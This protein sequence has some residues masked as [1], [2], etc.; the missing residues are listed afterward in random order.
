MLDPKLIQQ[1]ECTMNRKISNIL[2]ISPVKLTLGWKA[3]GA[4]KVLAKAKVEF[5]EKRYQ[6]ALEFLRGISPESDIPDVWELSARCNHFLGD[7]VAEAS[8][9]RIAT[10]LTG[11]KDFKIC[12]AEA[13]V[14]AGN[15]NEAERLL[16]NMEKTYFEDGDVLKTLAGVYYQLGSFARAYEYSSK[17]INLLDASLQTYLNAASIASRA[18][19]FGAGLRLVEDARTKFGQS[20]LLLEAEARIERDSGNC[21]RALS[22]MNTAVAADADNLNFLIA[23]GNF[24]FELGNYEEALNDAKVFL[25]NKPNDLPALRLL[26]EVQEKMAA[27][28]EFEKTTSLIKIATEKQASNTHTPKPNAQISDEVQRAELLA[29]VRSNPQNKVAIRFLLDRAKRTGKVKSIYGWIER[30]RSCDDFAVEDALVCGQALFEV[31][32][33]QAAEDILWEFFE[34]YKHS[35]PYARYCLNVSRELE[36]Q[37]RA[38][39]AASAV[40]HSL[41]LKSSNAEGSHVYERDIQAAFQD[42]VWLHFNAADLDAAD[43]VLEEYQLTYPEHSFVLEV[44]ASI[45]LERRQ[46]DVAEDWISRYRNLYPNYGRGP[47]MELTALLGGLDLSKAASISEDDGSLEKL[48]EHERVHI[49]SYANAIASLQSSGKDG[50]PSIVLDVTSLSKVVSEGASP[51]GIERTIV[52]VALYLL[53]N[54]ALRIKLVVWKT[55]PVVVDPAAFIVAVTSKQSIH[56]N[57]TLKSFASRELC[58][59]DKL[60]NF[61]VGDHAVILG[62][63]WHYDAN[64]SIMAAYKACGVDVALYIHD[65]LQLYYPTLVS[66]KWAH[67][68][69]QWIGTALD[70]ADI[71]MVNSNHSGYEIDQ[72][73]RETGR[74]KKSWT[75]V[76][77]GDDYRKQTII[78]GGTNPKVASLVHGTDKEQFVLYV[79][80]IGRRKNHL[81]LLSVWEKLAMLNPGRCPTLVLVG[82]PSDAYREVQAQLHKTQFGGGKVKLLQNISDDDLNLLYKASL[83]TVFPSI[84]EGWGLPIAEALTRG[85]VCLA[86]N[87]TSMPEVGGAYAD[88]FDPSDE[89]E[90]L[91]LISSYVFDR[92]KLATREAEI[93][94]GYVRRKWHNTAEGIV[95][96]LDFDRLPSRSGATEVVRLGGVIQICASW[97]K[98]CGIASYTGHVSKAL[99]NHGYNNAIFRSIDDALPLLLTGGYDHLLVQHEY[100]LY[101]NFNPTL[102]GPDSTEHL[103]QQMERYSSFFRHLSQAIIMHTIDM[104][105]PDLRSRTQEIMS[106]KIPVIS[107]SSEAA[108]NSRALFLEHG[109]VG[110]EAPTIP[111]MRTVDGKLKVASF[112]FLSPHKRVDKFLAACKA[113]SAEVVANFS[114]ES[115][116]LIRQTEQLFANSGVTGSL[117]FEFQSD[118]DVQALLQ[119]GDV[120]YFPQGPISYWATTGSAR[121]AMNAERP[122]IT[123]IEDQFEDLAR[124]V[125]FSSEAQLPNVLRRLRNQE[126]YEVALRNLDDFRKDFGIGSVYHDLFSSLRNSDES[127]TFSKSGKAIDISK[128]FEQPNW[129]D[130]T[131]AAILG[132]TP[133]QGDR[134]K[135]L[136]GGASP[137]DIAFDLACHGI[138]Q[139]LSVDIV[140]GSGQRGAL[141]AHELS[142]YD[143]VSVVSLVPI[144]MGG[145]AFADRSITKGGR[146]VIDLSADSD[147]KFDHVLQASRSLVKIANENRRKTKHG[148][149]RVYL[150]TLPAVPTRIQNSRLHYS[151]IELLAYDEEL[152]PIGVYRSIAKR[153]PSVQEYFA[154]LSADWAGRRD[155]IDK[156]VEQSISIELHDSGANVEQILQKKEEVLSY[157]EAVADRSAL[158]LVGDNKAKL[159]RVRLARASE[160]FAICETM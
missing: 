110:A 71:V 3:G 24:H 55:V 92:T 152:F 40:L 83:L 49:K 10:E 87:T 17:S 12:E 15:L 134:E 1:Q 39:E 95:A 31:D 115:D 52:E 140:T 68:F 23:R 4:I 36:H 151:L 75:K 120:V 109:V 18:G 66:E 129:F 38:V 80:A 85:K 6:N 142:R 33:K 82:S 86:S 149:N 122:V 121:V 145:F 153:D 54:P 91:A 42:L 46:F 22:L 101:D 77:L 102:A 27:V 57:P 21:S 146:H 69:R 63:A 62:S 2:G 143:N 61:T 32:E 104:N 19:E 50:T 60:Y 114:C 137:I 108:R 70:L 130:A 103:T 47:M 123:S 132:R 160:A 16:R 58:E 29:S 148:D 125:I 7:F 111:A 100:G 133:N 37:R 35:V 141:A 43:E 155:L 56:L 84:C 147:G 41:R 30:L 26:A 14:R 72:F 126:Y 44:K 67:I 74:A 94:T 154:A 131:F 124:G 139:G 117:T 5:R 76:E 138:R 73:C 81:R 118:A 158:E 64:N 13:L 90:M 135:W 59:G 79:S 136:S 8:N 112:G 99:T 97:G 144:L 65:L 127:V 9:W 53:S 93:A 88:Y 98:K 20:G 107:L 11:R 34:N 157:L 159:A 48:S 96:L 116:A 156:L 78:E 105:K 25:E 128:M 28:A 119:R 51:G 45:A 106:S 89:D 113:A 150:S